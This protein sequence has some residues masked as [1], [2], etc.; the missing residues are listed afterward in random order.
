MGMEIGVPAGLKSIAG[1]SCAGREGDASPVFVM[2]LGRGR[3]GKT[4][5]AMALIQYYRLLGCDLQVW[6]MDQ[7]NTSHSLSRF[8]PEA[9]EPPVGSGFED[10]KLWLEG[11]IQDQSKAKYDAIVD[12]PGGDSTILR[13]AHEVR[14]VRML[15]RMGIRPVAVHVVGPSKAD[16][17]YLRQMAESGL[18]MPEATIIL[19]NGGVVQSGRAVDAAFLEII[20][21]EVV[22]DAVDKGAELITMPALPCMTAVMD[23]G[24]PF[25]EAGEGRCPAG[26]LPLSPFDQERTYIW[27]EEEIPKALQAWPPLWA[28]RGA[29]RISEVMTLGERDVEFG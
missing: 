27:F 23:L 22:R 10:R 28:P 1:K 29:R 24:L 7:Q 9:L 2:M 21:D 6:N 14:L 11:R 13:L 15:E 5:T 25:R 20:E 3:V 8:H 19:L 16:L 12:F 26:Q 18:F 17:D 4:A